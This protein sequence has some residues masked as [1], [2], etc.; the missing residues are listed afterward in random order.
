MKEPPVS[1]SIL[2]NAFRHTLLEIRNK[3]GITQIE[4]AKKSG[5]TRQCISLIESGQ[6]SPTILSFLKIAK[7]LNIPAT[8]FMSMFTNKAEF[9]GFE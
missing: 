5:L 4:L 2:K 8:D 6:A 1:I 7:A 3:H 9:Y